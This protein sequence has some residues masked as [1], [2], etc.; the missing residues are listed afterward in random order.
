[1][2][3][4]NLGSSIN[5]TLSSVKDKVAGS[6][7]DV[8]SK[9][10]A[11]LSNLAKGLGSMPPNLSSARLAASGLLNGA[12]AS[13]K[14]S[15]GTPS[16]YTTNSKSEVTPTDWRLT[17]GISGEFNYFYNDDNNLLMEPLQATQGVTFPVTPQVQLTH[18]AKYSP[19]SL[20][21]SN[22]AMQF[23]E[24]SEIG[25]INITGEFPIQNIIEGQY[26]LASIYFFRS[27]S[28]MFWGSE[29]LAG[30][31]PPMLYLSGYGD[32]YLPDV[33]CVLTSFMHSMPEDKD[34]IEIPMSYDK[35]STTWLPT[36][37]T[38]QITLQPIYSRTA[39]SDFN[40]KDFSNGELLSGGY[41]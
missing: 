39:V 32:S 30:T 21:H 31:P 11:S 9:A 5:T 14:T 41:I 27:V 25:A 3:F 13:K 12:S 15:C 19:Q 20:V 35:T 18:T 4:G 38:I 6:L 10:S 2:D 24:G 7:G 1:M 16:Y 28:K 29:D 37:S 26:L 36:L 33:P 23:Y 8:A 17:V 22:Y 40:M 34:Y